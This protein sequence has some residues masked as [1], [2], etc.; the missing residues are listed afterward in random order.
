[1]DAF[2]FNEIDGI[3]RAGDEN[4]KNESKNSLLNDSRDTS[5]DGFGKFNASNNNL[6]QVEDKT[7]RDFRTEHSTETNRRRYSTGQSEDSQRDRAA[8]LS[9]GKER[10]SKLSFYGSST[11]EDTISVSQSTSEESDVGDN[12]LK[13]K[14]DFHTVSQT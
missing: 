14:S 8:Y 1:L 9:R 13:K 12:H 6:T 11:R 7:N 3:Q 4:Q 2:Y 5:P 10:N